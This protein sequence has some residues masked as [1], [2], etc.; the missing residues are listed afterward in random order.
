MRAFVLHLTRARARKENAHELLM[1]CGLPG[2][3]WEAVDGKA[4][5]NSDIAAPLKGPGFEPDYPFDL[6]AGEVGCFLSHRQI[7][8]E[9]V[10]RDLAYAL[11]LE[12]DVKI[13]PMVFGVAQVLAE[14]NIDRVGYIQF[15]NKSPGRPRVIDL[16]GAA[17]LTQPEVTPL[18]CSAQLI[19]GWVAKQLLDMTASFDRPVDTFVQS[20]WHTGLRPGVI[21]PSGIETI[22][23]QLDGSTI[24]TETGRLAVDIVKREWSRFSYR[25]KVA[26]FSAQSGAPTVDVS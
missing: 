13:D 19:S 24:Q 8:A 12:D 4:L 7:W 17:M 26:K 18:R 15:Q 25:R 21:F 11:V 10:R 6:S 23:D 1:T 22:S 9:I 14:R 3:I 20:H 5:S 2:E 16:E